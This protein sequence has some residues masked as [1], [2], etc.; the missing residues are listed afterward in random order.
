MEI[1]TNIT[2]KILVNQGNNTTQFPMLISSTT[3]EMGILYL[4]YILLIL[5][6][7]AGNSVLIHII[8][9]RHFMKTATNRLILNQACADLITTLISM[10][11]MFSDSLFY[12]KWHG[13]TGSLVGCKIVMWVVYLPQFCSVWTLTAI[14]IDRYFGV[15][16]PLL[17]SPISRHIR[18][19]IMGLWVW[20]FASAAGIGAMAR[21]VFV[22]R[23]LFCVIDYFHVKMTAVNI[24]ALCLLFLNFLVPLLV[25]TALYSIV[26]WRLW[27]RDPPGE[28]AGHDQRHEEAMKTAKK[29]TRMMIVVVVLFVLCWCPFHVF[30][31]LDSFHKIT[32]PYPALKFVVWLSNA[33]SAINPF[34][35]FSFNSNFKHELKLIF[36]KCCR[37]LKC[38][39]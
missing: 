3:I 13:G 34:V 15:M 11:A 24:T 30:V 2:A 6:S 5:T 29:V 27:S 14:A 39:T 9:T 31:G 10:P 33:Y 21:L 32:L 35:Y 37:R 7:L 22:N 4:G 16:R 26:C 36:G 25:M 12:R 20:A 19:V 17:S 8:R 23:H 18:L 1:P 28:G 38:C